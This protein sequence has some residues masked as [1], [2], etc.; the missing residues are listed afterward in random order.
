MKG[1]TP[2]HGLDSAFLR[3]A[4]AEEHLTDLQG[5]LDAL[6]REYQ[7]AFMPEFDPNPPYNF[8]VRSRI[9][10]PAVIPVPA[11]SAILIGEICYNLRCSLDYLVYAL[12]FLNTNRQPTGTQ[13]PIESNS[14]VFKSRRHTQLKGVGD[15]HGAMIER[16]QPYDRPNWLA[17]LRDFNDFDKHNRFVNIKARAIITRGSFSGPATYV[18]RTPPSYPDGEMKVNVSIAIEILFNN[19]SL[20]TETIEEI[21]SGVAETLE[22]FKAD[23]SG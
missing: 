1:T 3:V 19:R 13:F 23:F 20:I 18:I 12:A 9:G 16:C 7:Y 22:A 6:A 4:R 15:A 8:I 11:A 21:K 2:R 17:S 10:K 5:R 14:E